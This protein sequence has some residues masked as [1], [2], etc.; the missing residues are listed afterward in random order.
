VIRTSSFSASS[1]DSQTVL[2]NS[3]GP[4]TAKSAETAQEVPTQ[5]A[6]QPTNNEP[7]RCWICFNDE[8]E[9][10]ETSSEWRSPCPCVLVAHESCLLDWVADMEAPSSRRRAGKSGKI[11]CPQCKSEIRIERPR[12]VVVDTVRVVERLTRYM[13]L[14]GYVVLAGTGVYAT[15]R[16]IGKYMVFEIFGPEDSKRIMAPLQQTLNT[17]VTWLPMRLLY[18]LHDHWRLDIGLPMIPAVLMMSRSTIADPIL[19]FIPLIFFAGEGEARWQTL[20][21]LTWPPSAAFTIAALPYARSIYNA[22]YKHV[23]LPHEQRWIKEIQPRAGTE[24]PVDADAAGEDDRLA[25]LDAMAED[26]TDDEVEADAAQFDVELDVF[27]DWNNGGAADNHNAPENPPVPIARGPAHPLNAPPVEDGAVPEP[28]V[29]RRPAPPRR[30][31]L[32]REPLNFDFSISDTILSP[33]VFPSIAAA[34]GKALEYVLPS[35]WVTPPASGQPS[36]LLQARWGRSIVGGCL[37]VG[38]KDAILLY[39]RWRI[40]QNHRHRRVLDCKKSKGMGKAK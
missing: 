14:P 40:A 7:R 19:P 16:S 13:M 32:R 9:D 28:N 11:L 38:I 5:D 23:C 18:H 33:L 36:G 39:V 30:Q 31:R 26:D 8:T 10:D 27:A 22:F 35:S 12:D 1:V 4:E 37:F 6:P 2:L 21:E 29:P 15:L 24:D 34:I 3:H 17:H 20:S 25:I